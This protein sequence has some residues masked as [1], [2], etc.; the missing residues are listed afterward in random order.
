MAGQAGQA[1]QAGAAGAAGAGGGCVP[2]SLTGRTWA[3]AEVDLIGGAPIYPDV[4][5][6]SQGNPVVAFTKGSASSRFA[7]VAAFDGSAWGA[8]EVVETIANRYLGKRPSIAVEQDGALDVVAYDEDEGDVR[9]GRR[10]ASGTWTVTTPYD[11]SVDAGDHSSLFLDASGALHLTFL[12]YGT[13]NLVYGKRVEGTWSA[14]EPI[15]TAGG[16][17]RGSSSSVVADGSGIPRVAYYTGGTTTDLRFALPAAG[18]WAEEIVDPTPDAGHYPSL[19]LDDTGNEWIA[20]LR[21]PVSESEI[22]VASREAGAW[23]VR[24]VDT[25]L[26][27]SYTT[28]IA[29]LPCGG[30]G[31]AWARN[32]GVGQGGLWFAYL[33]PGDTEFTRVLVDG[34]SYVSGIAMAADAQ[35]RIHI[36]YLDESSFTLEHAMLP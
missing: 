12:Q 24:T 25:G 2:F 32:E 15:S 3:L 21:W 10:P 31:I 35:G 26:G 16:P 29:P 5:L 8:P 30:M 34:S 22:R 11:T 20:Y 17:V 23:E 19:A 14:F 13:Y 36:V 4:A 1:G 7:A 6:D 18:V 33:N 9:V 27:I 28:G